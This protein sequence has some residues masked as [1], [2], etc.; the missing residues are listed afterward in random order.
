M[1]KLLDHARNQGLPILAAAAGAAQVAGLQ[2][3]AAAVFADVGQKL[4]RYRDQQQS[5]ALTDDPTERLQQMLEELGYMA[6]L[7]ED[8]DLARAARRRQTVEIVLNALMRLA[9][10]LQESAEVAS[11]TVARVAL[12]EG[13]ALDQ[14]MDRLALDRE[15][16][17]RRDDGVDER[18]GVR[19]MTLHAAKGLEFPVVFLPGWE[20]GVMPHRRALEDAARVPAASEAP[21]ADGEEVPREAAGTGGVRADIA[22]VE[23]ERRLAYVGITRARELLFITRAVARRKYGKV[24][25]RVPSRFLA[26][27]PEGDVEVE[28]QSDA[29]LTPEQQRQNAADMFRK[30]RDQMG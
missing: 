6:H 5:A 15:D 27:L 25:P 23:E 4:M 20:D 29:A 17:D 14:L 7:E 2:K 28:D 9:T 16:G 26:E 30:L 24:T 10:R 11:E 1:D 3:K 21:P 13:N 12:D 8:G 22:G 18:P 19:L